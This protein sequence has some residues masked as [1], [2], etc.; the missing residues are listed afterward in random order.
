MCGGEIGKRGLL[1]KEFGNSRLLVWRLHDGGCWG[2]G[3]LIRSA[4]FGCGCSCSCWCRGC[5]TGAAGGKGPDQ[6]HSRLLSGACWRGSVS[7]PGEAVRTFFTG[8]C[9]LLYPVF[10]IMWYM[11]GMST[12]AAIAVS[13]WFPTN[14]PSQHCQSPFL[15]GPRCVVKL[16]RAASTPFPL[17]PHPPLQAQRLQDD[18]TPLLL[19]PLPFFEPFLPTL[20]LNAGA[21]QRLHPFPFAPS[22]PSSSAEAS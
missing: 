2:R 11:V 16:N 19:P 3:G 20:S 5:R 17:P 7:A 18:C 9:A 8:R 13:S 12:S 15:E 22:A 6:V 21:S 1:Q 10:A 4:V 14:L